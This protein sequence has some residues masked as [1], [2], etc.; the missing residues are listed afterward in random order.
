MEPPGVWALRRAPN[1]LRDGLVGDDDRAEV[2]T[3]VDEDGSGPKRPPAGV[4]ALAALDGPTTTALGHRAAAE[5]RRDGDARCTC[6]GDEDD[7]C[8]TRVGEKR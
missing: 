2:I 8:I 1:R 5:S 3:R 6:Q 4:H 7:R